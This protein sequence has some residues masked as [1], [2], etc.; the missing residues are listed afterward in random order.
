MRWSARGQ[1]AAST[2]PISP[3][4]TPRTWERWPSTASTAKNFFPMPASMASPMERNC[5]RMW[6]W[7]EAP[8]QSSRCMVAGQ[9][10]EAMERQPVSPVTIIL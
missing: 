4:A 8:S 3:A 9:W 1:V 7:G 10:W 2:A 5:R 6:E